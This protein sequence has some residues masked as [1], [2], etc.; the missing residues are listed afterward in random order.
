[1][2]QLWRIFVAFSWKLMLAYVRLMVAWQFDSLGCTFLTS[3]S[4][5][6]NFRLTMKNIGHI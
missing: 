1:M 6:S 5:N 4:N 2:T 3:L